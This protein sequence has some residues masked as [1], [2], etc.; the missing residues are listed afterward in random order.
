MRSHAQD[1]DRLMFVP[2]LR[3]I[4]ADVRG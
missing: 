4:R 2:L 3:Y 1:E